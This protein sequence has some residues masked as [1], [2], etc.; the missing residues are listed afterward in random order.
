M[1]VRVWE[2]LISRKK[3]LCLAQHSSGIYLLWNISFESFWQ[4]LQKFEQN[5]K[6]KLEQR[7][8]NSWRREEKDEQ[9]RKKKTPLKIKILWIHNSFF[10]SVTSKAIPESCCC[11]TTSAGH[12]LWIYRPLIG[13]SYIA[14]ARQV[15]I[16]RN[17]SDPLGRLGSL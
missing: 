11:V 7:R 13:M 10:S 1:R 14:L 3:K 8:L 6:A 5:I 17:I 12:P 15:Q 2:L 4:I 9:S 16:Y